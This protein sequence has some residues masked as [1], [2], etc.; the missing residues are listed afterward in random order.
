MSHEEKPKNTLLKKLN[1]ILSEPSKW[2]E[3][4]IGNKNLLCLGNYK[5]M[6]IIDSVSSLRI[7]SRA[8]GFEQIFLRPRFY[9]LCL[10]RERI[11]ISEPHQAALLGFPVNPDIFFLLL[12][13]AFERLLHL[14]GAPLKIRINRFCCLPTNFLLFI[15]QSAPL[16]NCKTFSFWGNYVWS[17]KNDL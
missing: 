4:K 7:I 11:L 10:F 9:S 5:G 16:Y 3:L 14:V 2:F 6:K 1:E 17:P 8:T 13:L 15:Q 12:P